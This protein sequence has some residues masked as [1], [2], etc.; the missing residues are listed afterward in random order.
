[1]LFD[2][3][4]PIESI[5]KSDKQAALRQQKMMGTSSSFIREPED[6]ASRPQDFERDMYASRMAIELNKLKYKNR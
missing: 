4:T 5:K 1:M 3:T 2:Y 6:R